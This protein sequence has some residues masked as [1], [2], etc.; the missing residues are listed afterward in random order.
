[1]YYDLCSVQS[2]QRMLCHCICSSHPPL[3]PAVVQTAPTASTRTSAARRTTCCRWGLGGPQQPGLPAP[4]SDPVGWRQLSALCMHQ[5]HA[6]GTCISHSCPPPAHLCLPLQNVLLTYERYNQVSWCCSSLH[7]GPSG[8][9]PVLPVEPLE[10]EQHSGPDALPWLPKLHVC[11]AQSAHLPHTRP[12]SAR[13]WAMCRACPT[14]W[15]PSCE[16][17][18]GGCWLPRDAG[19]DVCQ[20]ACFL[21]Q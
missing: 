18:S 1:M 19:L 16:G 14:C 8:S 21:S 2:D 15:R 11:R 17:C 7:H 13:T 10:G 6:S 4:H 9:Q 3:H 5:R 20:R 12:L